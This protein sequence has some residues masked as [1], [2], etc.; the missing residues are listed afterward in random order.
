MEPLLS[1]VGRLGVGPIAQQILN[2]MFE[3]P[4]DVNENTAKYIQQLART[5]SEYVPEHW[6]LRSDILRE[7]WKKAKENTASGPSGLTFAHF[8]ANA[9]DGEV[10]EFDFLM[11][12][13]PYTTGLMPERW[14]HGTNVWLEKMKGDFNV[15][16]L[17]MIF[18]VQSRIQPFEQIHRSPTYAER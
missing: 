16:R 10:S 2:G 14:K 13:I 8:I 11:S 15:E 5:R 4:P 3:C 17:R 9:H 12:K 18:V 1:L 7:G 6:E